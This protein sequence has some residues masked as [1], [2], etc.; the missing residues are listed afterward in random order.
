MKAKSKINIKG[1][2]KGKWKAKLLFILAYSAVLIVIVVA[3]GNYPEPTGYT[4]DTG[5]TIWEM[6]E[7]H[8]PD[9]MDIRDFVT[10]IKKAND[11]YDSV[12]HK[13]YSYKIPVYKTESEY[14]DMNTVV[15]YETSD[16]GV[17]LL[18]DDGNGYFVEK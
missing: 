16:D 5:K 2:R 4:Y 14:L 7:R 17:L 3:K 15:G 8:C 13:G 9:D 6:A 10:E 18:T 1:N 11:M 12:V